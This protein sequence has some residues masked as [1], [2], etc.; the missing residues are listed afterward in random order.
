MGTYN[1]RG[2][3]GTQILSLYTCYAIAK[4]NN[5]TVN[6]I[7][8]NTG[9]Y[10]QNSDIIMDEDR[11]FF[12]DFLTFKKRPE[13]TTVIGTNKTNPFKEPNVSLLLKWW[14]NIN[15]SEVSLNLN[16]CDY[17]NYGKTVIHVRQSDRPL[18]PIEVYDE[19]IRYHKN[20]IILSED[21]SVHKR[22]GITPT[23]DTIKDWMTIYQAHTVIG[24]FSSFALLAGMWNPNLNVYFFNKLLANPNVSFDVWNIIHKF[25]EKFPNINWT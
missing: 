5:T 21:K 1:V 22:Y 12:D 13:I 2:G 6:K 18:I 14:E 4:E 16:G 9:G 8:F 15:E 23:N 25:V 24:G 19:E 20:P 10:W 17:V 11:I 7:L 3:L